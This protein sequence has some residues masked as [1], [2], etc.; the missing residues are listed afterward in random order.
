MDKVIITGSP[1]PMTIHS[2]D[3]DFMSVRVD[4]TERLDMTWTSH[5][6]FKARQFL[7]S[8]K[9]LKLNLTI[10]IR[11]FWEKD[12]NIRTM[13]RRYTE[14]FFQHFNMGYVNYAEGEWAVA[15]RMLA[16]TQTL[17]GVEDGPSSAILRFMEDQQFDPPKDWCG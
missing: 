2:V 7:E 11:D 5:K 9:S 17:L 1:F 16:S 12:R 15:R 8:E 6:R 3:L 10:E 4:N 13:R 14:Q